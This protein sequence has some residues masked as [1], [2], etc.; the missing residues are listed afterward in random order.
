MACSIGA[1]GFEVECEAEVAHASGP[2][3]SIPVATDSAVERDITLEDMVSFR[4]VHEPRQ[5][6]NGRWVAF[7]VRQAFRSCDCYRVALYVVAS[8]GRDRPQKLIEQSTITH[9]QWAPDGESVTFL[10]SDKGSTQIWRLDLKTRRASE[11]LAQSPKEASASTQAVPKSQSPGDAKILDYVWAPNGENIALVVD[12]PIDP[13]QAAVAARD[14]FRYDESTMGARD[15]IAG[16]WA[17][18]KRSTQLWLYNIRAKRQ[19]LVWTTSHRWLSRIEALSWSPS[20]KSLAFFYSGADGGEADEMALV[21]AGSLSISVQGTAGGDIRSPES[22]AWSHDERAIAYLSSSVRS[23]YVLYIRSLI[24]QSVRKIS[25]RIR[26]GAL[27]WL[28]WDS[29]RHTLLFL[30]NGIANDRRTTGL[31]SLSEGG[32]EE[33]RLT[34][35]TE[36]VEDC[37]VVSKAQMACVRQGVS[38]APTPALIN[39]DNGT[40]R[41]IA[42]VN[43]EF[44]SIR[45]QPVRELHWKNAYG[46]ETSGFLILPRRASA[47]GRVPLVLIGYN[48]SGEFVTRASGNLTTYP[49]QAL[50]RDGIAVLLFNPPRYE[51]WE[52]PDFARGSRAFGYGPLSSMQAIISLLNAE[53]R[54]DPNHVGMMGHSLSGFWAQ[55]AITQTNLLSV[56]EL[57]NGGTL[58]EPGM[59]WEA[60]MKQIREAQEEIMGGPPYGDTYKNYQSVA[61]SLNANRIRAPILMEYDAEEALAALE[62][63]AALQHYHVPVDFFVYPND[64]H[65]TSRPEHQLIS[66]QR[67]LD[68]FEFWL[69]GRENDASL[70]ADQY[71]H[72]RN[73]KVLADQ[74][75]K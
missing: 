34:A 74:K 40:A 66:S 45:L 36:K 31:Y 6:P 35:L 24:D 32:G 22:V 39:T 47:E 41:S 61:F 62:Y 27:P 11:V 29:D 46:D 50:A 37:G 60:G 25:D 15:L 75:A 1:C 33:T 72:W 49:A 69:L 56:V 19:H 42:E 68:W 5:S 26:P 63:Y 3:I 48:F 21:D 28:H 9:L 53:G 17:V 54:I 43:P 38:T 8:E 10:S 67:N 7:L 20:G 58:S 13:S 14:G 70:K 55:L 65:V 18:A 2:S 12:P 23:A 59:Y 73:L 64:G 52:G 44:K 57:H 4:D 30:S 51:D 71:A 16:D